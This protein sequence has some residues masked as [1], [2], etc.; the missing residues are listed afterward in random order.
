[1]KINRYQNNPIVIPGKYDWRKV[2]TFNPA[3]IYENNKFYMFERACSNLQPLQCRIGLLES[4]D[5]YNF[6]HVY[7]EPVFTPEQLGC[8]AGTIEDPR[9]VKLDDTYYLVFAHRPFNYNCY[10]TGIAEPVYTTVIGERF[11]GINNTRSGIATSKNMKD[12]EFLSFI[13]SQEVD[14]RD[15]VLFPEKINGKYAMLR[16]PMSYF[17]EKYGCSGPSMWISYSEDLKTFSDPVL[18]AG[19]ENDWEG[20]K[21][22]ASAPPIKTDKGW[23]TIYHGV[24]ENTVYRVGVML[25]DLE[26]PEKVIARS[27]HYIM[28]PEAYYEKVGLIIPNVIFPTA[29]VVKAGLLYIY[30]GCTDTCISVATVQLKDILD[31]VLQY[32]K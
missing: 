19:P 4:D 11:K 24:D 15:N 13:N 12:W 7:D 23:L 20:G 17:G 1:M 25:L 31:Y 6:K 14:D 3:C 2:A 22:G 10:P 29:N 27:P 28:E 26:N 5:G 32:K 9:V 18:V 16:R 30:Y 21:I 8:P